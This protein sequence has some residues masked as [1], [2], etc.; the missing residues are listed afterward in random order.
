LDPIQPRLS[1]GKIH[2]SLVHALIEDIQSQT[3]TN[4]GMD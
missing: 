3:K 1:T 2:G 4:S